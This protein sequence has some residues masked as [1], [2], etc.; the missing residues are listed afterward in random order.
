MAI[1]LHIGMKFLCENGITFE[2]FNKKD[3]PW[4]TCITCPL[5]AR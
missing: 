2:F 4:T 5:S 1:Y 3:V